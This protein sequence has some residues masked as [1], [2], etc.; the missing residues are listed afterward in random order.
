MPPAAQPEVQPEVQDTYRTPAILMGPTI[1]LAVLLS[2]ILA[3]VFL[4]HHIVNTIRKRGNQDEPAQNSNTHEYPLFWNV[5]IPFFR[6]FIYDCLRRSKLDFSKYLN[7]EEVTP[8]N[9]KILSLR[10]QMIKDRMVSVNRLLTGKGFITAMDML[11]D[12]DEE[13]QKRGGYFYALVLHTRDI[14]WDKAKKY[15]YGYE[16]ETGE[17]LPLCWFRAFLKTGRTNSDCLT[18]YEVDSMFPEMEIEE[19]K[20]KAEKIKKELERKR[21][22]SRAK[23]NLFEPMNPQTSRRPEAM[24]SN[25]PE[26][27]QGP[28]STNEEHIPEEEGSNAPA[29]QVTDS[30]PHAQLPA[31]PIV[32]PH[33]AS[34]IETEDRLYSSNRSARSSL[35]LENHRHY[36]SSLSNLHHRP[37]MSRHPS[38]SSFF[39]TVTNM[40]HVLTNSL[41]ATPRASIELPDLELQKVEEAPMNKER[42]DQAKH[43]AQVAQQ[44]KSAEPCEEEED[45]CPICLDVLDQM[46]EEETL[47]QDDA[48]DADVETT[49]TETDLSTQPTESTSSPLSPSTLVS[50]TEFKGHV[51]NERVPNLVES[52]RQNNFE[53]LVGREPKIPRK[54]K[55]RVLT[56]SHIFHNE[57]I[58]DWLT[59]E[60]GSCPLCSRILI[61][62]IPASV[63]NSQAGLTY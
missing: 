14:L 43:L 23:D 6:E 25:E 26:Q 10:D 16:N 48:N 37:N 58:F 21:D 50:D 17:L 61:N 4:V 2:P 29:E 3:I 7:E 56:C 19:A 5:D 44:P 33:I 42:L 1:I 38:T 9:P 34:I 54:Q 59:Q 35:D 31:F 13:I 60:K 18:I 27:I 40:A 15:G 49:K 32:N 28:E 57:C 52:G 51:D 39:S 24:V 11:F 8:K 36:H 30:I 47:P 12:E 63:L 46:V 55:L 62:D 22:S 45:I 20:V 41:V 53:S